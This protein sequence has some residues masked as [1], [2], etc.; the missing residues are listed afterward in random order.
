MV[1]DASNNFRRFVGI[2]TKGAGKRKTDERDS[3]LFPN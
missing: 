2:M 3:N 1:I